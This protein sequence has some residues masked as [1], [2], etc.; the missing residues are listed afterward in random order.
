MESNKREIADHLERATAI[1]NEAERAKRRLTNSERKTVEGHLERVEEVKEQDQLRNEIAKMNAGVAGPGG[2]DFA[3]A[4][5]SAGFNLKSN[6][7]VTI[8]LRT[9]LGK[10]PTLPAVGDWN[11]ADPVVVPMGRDQRFVNAN[12]IQQSVDGETAIQDF[13][14]TARTVTGSVQ[15]AL[16]AST[17]KATLDVTLSLV[18][19]TLVQ[20]AILIPDV[21]NAVFEAVPSLREFLNSEGRFQINKALDSHAMSQIVAASPPFGQTGSELITKIRNGVASMRAEGAN[22]S[23]AVL[24]PS[25]AATL[26]L[27][28]DAG[29]F[30]FATRDTGSASPLWGLRVVERIGAGTEA[31]YLLDVGMLGRFYL[32]TLRFEVDPFTGFSKNLSTLRLEIKSLYHVRN[33]KG[34]RRVAAA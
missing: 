2:S 29:G 9:A 1:L 11:R 14:Q 25:D 28:A 34:A 33:A 20:Q 26:D 3:Q 16:D 32:G 8:P 21:P 23:V 7:S 19:E 4:V 6:P 13:R 22:P 31:P 18:T 10:A 30:I 24:N 27:Q 17:D 12:L 15:R 5:V